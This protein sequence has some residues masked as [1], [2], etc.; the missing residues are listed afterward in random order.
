[1]YVVYLLYIYQFNERVITFVRKLYL[2][3]Y[4]IYSVCLHLM[5]YLSGTSD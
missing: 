4:T 2:T 5:F 3:L 1:M